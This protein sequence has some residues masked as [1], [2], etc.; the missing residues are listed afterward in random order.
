MNEV[1][2]ANCRI[3]YADLTIIIFTLIGMYLI[4]FIPNNIF[5]IIILLITIIF[6][7]KRNLLYNLLRKV[8]L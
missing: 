7:L 3:Q 8:G 6:S 4:L 2:P 1:I 5:G